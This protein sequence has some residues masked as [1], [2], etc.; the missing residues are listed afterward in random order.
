MEARKV[1][2]PR[3]SADLTHRVIG[4]AMRVHSELGPGFL[5]SVYERAILVELRE[6]GLNAEAQVP[7]RVMYRQKHE[8]GSFIADIVVEDCLILELKA[9][10]TLPP[11]AMAQLQTDLR[12]TGFQVGLLLNFGKPRLDFQRAVFNYQEPQA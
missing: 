1:I 8:V 7:L 12:C 6:A 4:L 10:A 11:V 2:G 9:L 5:E 3:V